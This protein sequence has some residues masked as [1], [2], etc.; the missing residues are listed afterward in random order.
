MKKIALMI[1]IAAAALL[2]R[3]GDGEAEPFKGGWGSF[4]KLEGGETKSLKTK[5]RGGKRA[6]VI[7][8]GD[9]DPV[10]PLKVEVFDADGKL[11]AREATSDLGAAAPFPAGTDLAAVIWYPPRDADYT[12]K[13]TNLSTQWNKVW[14]AVK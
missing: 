2:L 5:F 7:A 14:I 3:P 4:Y 10:V 12:V 1:V 13:V 9:H 11:V 6:S 8:M